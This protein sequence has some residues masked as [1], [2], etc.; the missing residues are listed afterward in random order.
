VYDSKGALDFIRG[1]TSFAVLGH[2]EPDGDCVASQLCVAALL[3]AL[4]KT[5]TLH[6][7]GP[8]DRPEIA[9]FGRDFSSTLDGAAAPGRAAIIVDCSTPDRTGALGQRITGLP[10]LVIDH[11]S[12]GSPFGTARFVDSRAPSTTMLIYQL[13]VDAGLRPDRET[14]RLLLFG[15]CTDTGFFR[16]LGPGSEE[17]FSAVAGLSACG[18]ST[19]DVYMM[20]YGRREL[21]SRRLLAEMLSRVEN[22]WE[23]R[24]L[25][26][27]QTI[28]DR[29][30]LGVTQ[31]GDDDLYRLLQTIRGNVVVALI[32]QEGEGKY[33]VGLRSTEAV[34]VGAIAA[35]FGGGGHR[36][37][38]GFDISGTLDSVKKTVVDALAPLLERPPA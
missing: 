18:T 33:S 29:T 4:G 30:R 1:H 3:R 2:R 31:R 11:H 13:F 24:L 22:P 6:S 36:Q 23:D 20:V 10:C 19:A 34:D 27:W 5:A 8:F 35:S 12:A 14:A 26:T 7:V 17:T 21:A 32:K 16:H 25:L 37:A 9:T 38:S 15:L 28:E